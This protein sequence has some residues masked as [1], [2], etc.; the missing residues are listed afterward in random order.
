MCVICDFKSE[1]EVEINIHLRKHFGDTA[2]PRSKRIKADKEEPSRKSCLKCDKTFNTIEAAVEHCKAHRP[3][4]ISSF[5]CIV[6]LACVNNARLHTHVAEH[7][8]TSPVPLS[9]QHCQLEFPNEK[10]LKYH[11]CPAVR[12]FKCSKC[13]MGF[14]SES[15]LRFH[16]DF[17]ITKETYCKTCG[18]D[19][20]FESRIFLHLAG[21]HQG[22]RDNPFSC[23]SCGKTFRWMN[24]LRDHQRTH[25]EQKPFACGKCNA[26]F[27]SKGSLRSHLPSHDDTALLHCLRCEYSTSRK[28]NL[29]KHVAR[30]HKQVDRSQ[31]GPGLVFYFLLYCPFF[32]FSL[33]TTPYVVFVV[34]THPD[35]KESH[36]RHSLSLFYLLTIILHFLDST[37]FTV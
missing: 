29:L 27:R 18:K 17:H 14:K 1:S 2:P 36:K 32:D 4:D 21:V 10:T 3:T 7:F 24:A 33:S 35:R 9:C 19:F 30:L 13:K 37:Y 6:C 28:Q 16:E 23:D 5:T 12:K 15:R 25:S 20:K 8:R 34:C 22:E 11:R 26:T 31:V